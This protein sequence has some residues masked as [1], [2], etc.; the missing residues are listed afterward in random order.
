MFI[1]TKTK[2]EKREQSKESERE[3]ELYVLVVLSQPY[4]QR[5]STFEPEIEDYVLFGDLFRG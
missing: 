5:H 4:N 3:E 2:D 1:Q